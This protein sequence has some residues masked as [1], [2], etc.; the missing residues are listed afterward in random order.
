MDSAVPPFWTLHGQLIG[1][2]VDAPA[3][4]AINKLEAKA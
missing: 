3:H 4:M 2:V 1:R